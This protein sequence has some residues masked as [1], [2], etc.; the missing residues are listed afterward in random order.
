MP[1]AHRKLSTPTRCRIV[2]LISGRGSNLE[3]IMQAAR[4]EEF[5]VELCA[6]ISNQPH[7]AGLWAARQQG[8]PAEVIDHRDFP[9][10]NAFERALM[11]RIDQRQ[12]HL[13][14]LAGF[15]R[16]LGPDFIDRYAGRLMNIHPSL[17][18][19]FPGLR[20]H[21]RALAA[22]ATQHG[23]TVH[24][25]THDVDSGPIIAQATVPVL[26]DDTAE[27]LAARVLT[28]EHRL[29][30]LAIRWFAE[31]RLT[32]RNGCVLLDGRAAAAQGLCEPPEVNPERK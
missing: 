18:P 3:A 27:T 13:V 4:D 28:E 15:L 29:Y 12:P 16:I 20:T 9:D 10:R 7:A 24:F 19:A 11:E 23:A 1:R 8:I 2:I 26:P 32:L 31:G 17:L 21:E 5:P 22:G 25:V 30:P 6:V 14:A